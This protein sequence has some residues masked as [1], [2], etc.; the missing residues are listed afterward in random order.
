MDN[1]LRERLRTARINCLIAAQSASSKQEKLEAYDRASK[2]ET[3]VVE[4]AFSR[5]CSVQEIG[6]AQTGH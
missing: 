6:D 2:E 5:G 4:E 1:E 3:A